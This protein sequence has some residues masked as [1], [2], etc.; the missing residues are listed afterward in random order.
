[1]AVPNSA[2]SARLR[3]T[4]GGTR[5][6]PSSRRA[7]GHRTSVAITQRRKATMAMGSASASSFATATLA[8]TSAID[9]PSCR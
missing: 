1:M 8:P 2:W 6:L 3:S 9:R 5:S 4:S 7:S